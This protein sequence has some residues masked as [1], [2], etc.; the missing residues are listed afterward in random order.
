MKTVVTF[1]IVILALFACDASKSN[2][3]VPKNDLSQD[4][5]SCIK[6][7]KGFEI[8]PRYFTVSAKEASIIELPNGGSIKFEENC[9]ALNGKPIKDS[10]TIEWQEFHSITDIMCSGIPMKYDSAG[11]SNDFI[12]GGMF[13]IKGKLGEQEV[14]FAKG[15]EAEVSI[16]SNR[17]KESFNFYALDENSG[18][19]TFKKAKEATPNKKFVPRNETSDQPII[20][21][22]NSFIFEVTLDVSQFPELKNL[23]ILGWKTHD[24][25]RI[26]NL[27]T[28]KSSNCTLKKS[29]VEGHY[30][31]VVDISHQLLTYD[32][33]PYLMEE[34]I[35]DSKLNK[36]EAEKDIAA[37]EKYQ[38]NLAQGKVLR[39]ISIKG[40]GTYNWDRFNLTT[41]FLELTANYVLPGSPHMR[42]V[43]LFYVSLD[44]NIIVAV[45]GA[46]ENLKLPKN[47][48]N[49]LVAI[50]PDNTI[51]YCPSEDFIGLDQLP[52]KA[53]HSFYFKKSNISI[54]SGAELSELLSK[55][56]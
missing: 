35:A 55:L 29:E 34:A 18:D 38:D 40:F 53:E 7:L 56:N 20:K 21:K 12:S 33:Q 2:L 36:V 3:E 15:K 45:D 5:I 42:T 48:K 50:L 1:S 47:P 39:S 37:I 9:F 19:W 16:A 30:N 43:S 28:N 10:V 41:N 52:R 8:K 32:V 49:C 31:M 17:D 24:K 54:D 46:N 26:K 11:I 13:T 23:D 4:N 44:G 22:Q 27:L 25:I 6:P 14:D 51:A